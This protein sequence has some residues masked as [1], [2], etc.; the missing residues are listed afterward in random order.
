MNLFSE[1]Y[2]IEGKM[3]LNGEKVYIKEP[4]D[5]YSKGIEI[6]A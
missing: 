1:E 2:I 4:N 5:A 6:F 3:F